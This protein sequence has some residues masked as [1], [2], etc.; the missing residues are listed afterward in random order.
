MPLAIA[1]LIAIVILTIAC[2]N[3]PP[4]DTP[5]PTAT[6]TP[7]PLATP[8]LAATLVSSVAATI[9][10]IPTNTPVEMDDPTPESTQPILTGWVTGWEYYGTECPD[11]DP[12]CVTIGAYDPDCPD[13]DPNCVIASNTDFIV[14]FSNHSLFYHRHSDQPTMPLVYQARLIIT[15]KILSFRGLEVISDTEPVI[16]T[17]N[18]L[19]SVWLVGSENQDKQYFTPDV[20]NPTMVM[21]ILDDY[22]S[23]IYL[24]R[25]AEA[26]NQTLVISAIAGIDHEPVIGLFDVT[27][28]TAYYN[29]LAC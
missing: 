26:R 29:R 19:F 27:G 6:P 25:L 24:I 14:L 21:L 13:N 23:I 8:D 16:G 22:K 18:T 1:A 4:T 9:A 7:D 3:P 20:V 15:C 10:A 11:N 2:A 28:F 12:S 5:A 17:D